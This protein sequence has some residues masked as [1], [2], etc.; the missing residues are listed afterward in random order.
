M[1]LIVL[2]SGIGSR[3]EDLTHNNPKCLVKINDKRIIDY[4]YELSTF[5]EETI[6]IGGYKYELLNDVLYNSKI[7]LNKEYLKTNMVHSLFKSIDYVEDDFIAV[8]ADIIFDNKIVTN[9]ISKKNTILPLKINWLEYWMQRMNINDIK[10]DA[11]NLLVNKNKIIEIGTKIKDKMPNYQ[12]MGILKFNYIDFL[13]LDVFY[14]KIKN[15]RI[16]MTSFLNLAIHN[17]VI[18][19]FY[20]STNDFWLEI[21]NKT[22]LNLAKKILRQKVK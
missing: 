5:F 4:M 9:L 22:D 17:Q 20:Q 7:I 10:K 12:Y 11:E 1:K 15:Q 14:K 21:D 2:A 8:Y 6:I 16:D 3:L 19:I 13:K 18:D